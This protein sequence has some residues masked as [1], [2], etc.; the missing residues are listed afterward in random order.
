MPPRGSGGTREPA[1]RV[2]FLLQSHSWSLRGSDGGVS[3][4]TPRGNDYPRSRATWAL[5]SPHARTAAPRW[6]GSKVQTSSLKL[7]VVK[8]AGTET[9]LSLE[10]AS[11]HNPCLP[12]QAW[13]K[14]PEPSV[15]V[16]RGIAGTVPVS[17]RKCTH[18]GPRAWAAG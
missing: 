6:A 13:A 18:P 17:L 12:R 4:R 2:L 1:I 7:L 5:F 11:W 14:T 8:D 16:P 9:G 15:P 10:L 3:E